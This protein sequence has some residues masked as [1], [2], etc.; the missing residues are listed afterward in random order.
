MHQQAPFDIAAF[1]VFSRIAET[2]LE[3]VRARLET[4]AEETEIVGLLILGTE[5][6]NATVA[7]AKA[8]IEA[9]LALIATLLGRGSLDA[10]WSRSPRAPFRKFAVKIRDEIVTLGRPGLRP[11]EADRSRHLSPEA[12]HEALQDPDSIVLDT[13][14]WYET[15]MGKF[16]GAIEPKIDEFHEFPGYLK[17]SRLPKDKRVL[18]YCTGGIRCEKAILEMDRQGFTDVRQLDGGILAY[19]EKFPDAGFQGD[20][21]VFDHRVAVDQKLQPSGR[22]GLCPHCGQPADVSVTCGRCDSPALICNDCN[23]KNAVLRTCSK[24]CAHHARLAP[25]KKGRPPARQG[26]RLAARP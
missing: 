19:L 5:G 2:R 1:Y 4:K 15:R 6:V 23:G 13:R 10:K 16:K 21:F 25:G 7:G 26:P 24:N 9:F 18:I 3:D 8:D 17:A 14:N 11:A 20:C 22:F 12:W